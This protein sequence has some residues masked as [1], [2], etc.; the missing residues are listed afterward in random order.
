LL[1]IVEFFVKHCCDYPQATQ[2]MEATD[3][4]TLSKNVNVKRAVSGQPSA[5]SGLL[6]RGFKTHLNQD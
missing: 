4:R 1:Y 5:V 2:A 3:I 6:K